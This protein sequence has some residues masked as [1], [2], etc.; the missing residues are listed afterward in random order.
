MNISM[1]RHGDPDYVN[2]SLTDKGF[3]DFP[4]LCRMIKPEIDWIFRI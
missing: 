4:H 2:D 3:K 1:V